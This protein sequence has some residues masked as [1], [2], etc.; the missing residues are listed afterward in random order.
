MSASGVAR[1]RRLRVQPV[2]ERQCECGGLSRAGLGDAD[3][4]VPFQDLRDGRRLDG[5]GFGVASF[6][7]GL[8][9]K[10]METEAFERHVWTA[11]SLS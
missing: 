5:R 10:G 7:D 11:S 9:N 4:V 6:L 1:P 2:K 3:Q 8:Q